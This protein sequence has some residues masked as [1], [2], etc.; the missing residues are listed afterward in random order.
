MELQPVQGDHGWAP[1]ACTLPTT[2]RPLREAEFDALFAEAV[3]A[4]ELNGP[5]RVRLV[6]RADPSV[7]GRVAELAARE[8]G[9]CSFF[10][11]TLTATGGA[12]TLEV[13][14]D[15]RHTGVL[16]ALAARATRL[17]AS[18]TARS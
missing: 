5:G 15:E 16:A 18:G 1:Q 3:T 2:E 8:T 14:V 13:G 12:L 9:C 4:V 11:F 6:L 10:T 17:S 7:A